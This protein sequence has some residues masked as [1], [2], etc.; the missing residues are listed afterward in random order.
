MLLV[1]MLKNI[2]LIISINNKRIIN[3]KT[4]RGFDSQCLFFF[5]VCSC[6]KNNICLLITANIVILTTKKI[7]SFFILEYMCIDQSK[8]KF[9]K[10]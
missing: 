2:T 9:L 10:N 5:K 3:K 6:F 7:C 4:D 8:C 1:S